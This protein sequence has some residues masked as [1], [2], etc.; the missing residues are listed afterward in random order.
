[1]YVTSAIRNAQFSVTRITVAQFTVAYLT[2]ADFTDPTKK[3]LP[4]FP[5]ALFSVAH[6][7]VFRC[8]VYRLPYKWS[9]W[10]RIHIVQHI[11]ITKNI[12]VLYMLITQISRYSRNGD[13]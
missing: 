2:V 4:N 7:S 8:P 11:I 6:F 5:V 1:M 12:N 10:L 9:H 13:T 3:L